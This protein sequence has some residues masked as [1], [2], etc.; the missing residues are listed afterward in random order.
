MKSLNIIV[1]CVEVFSKICY[2]NIFIWG[3]GNYVSF[4][5]KVFFVGFLLYN[6][7]IFI[8]FENLNISVRVFLIG[9]F[10]VVY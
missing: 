8:E 6:I 10:I 2:D 7:F 1:I 5:L 9:F 4:I 3:Y